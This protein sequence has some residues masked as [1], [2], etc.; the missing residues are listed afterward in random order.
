MDYLKPRFVIG[1]KTTASAEA[2]AEGYART[3][4][5]RRSPSV[6]CERC[7]SHV[8]AMWVHLPTD[9]QGCVVVREDLV[10]R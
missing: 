9:G 8:E 4:G 6:L 2:Y 7:G 1:P 10:E 5:A 3:F